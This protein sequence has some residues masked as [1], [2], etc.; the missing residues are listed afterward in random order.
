MRIDDLTVTNFNG[1]AHRTFSFNQHF[2][3]LVG[4]N[5]SGKTSVL[6]ALAVSVGGWFLGLR[7]YSHGRGIS[8]DEVRVVPHEH[9]DSYTFEKQ[10]PSRIECTGFVM[11]QRISWA[12][13]LRREGG[14]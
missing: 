2:N 8:A 5:G 10:F 14:R 6:D 4:D 11:E 7:G 12:R 1:F 3:L 9:P 13:E